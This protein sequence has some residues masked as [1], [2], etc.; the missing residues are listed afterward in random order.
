MT[1]SN[2]MNIP[3]RNLPDGVLTRIR[4]ISIERG[5]NVVFD[6]TFNVVF[7]VAF[8]VVF[9]V[10]FDVVFDLVFNVVFN[11]VVVIAHGSFFRIYARCQS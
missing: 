1:P 6:V 2:L 5:F 8:D 10:A 11:F 3:S 4:V 7:D 9:D